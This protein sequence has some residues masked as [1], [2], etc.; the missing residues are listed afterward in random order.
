MIASENIVENPLETRTI[1]IVLNDKI[2]DVLNNQEKIIYETQYNVSMMKY[3]H[4]I[5]EY[6]KSLSRE[7]YDNF[8]NNI[9]N[10]LLRLLFQQHP[11][12]EK[13]KNEII[14]STFRTALM[15][16]GG[17]NGEVRF[18][19]DN[20]LFPQENNMNCCISWGGVGTQAHTIQKSREYNEKRELLVE[21]R[22]YHLVREFSDE[23]LGDGYISSAGPDVNQNITALLVCGKEVMHRREPAPEYMYETPHYRYMLNVYYR[24]T[25]GS[26]YDPLGGNLRFPSQ[27]SL[28]N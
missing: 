19:M 11:F 20:M 26:P 3:K 4:Y 17:L 1:E 10:T 6:K 22:E 16:Q 15:T 25:Y 9:T 27:P 24:G 28:K 7:L 5:T 21:N 13:K 14:I 18:H 2:R 23:F 8:E 12:F